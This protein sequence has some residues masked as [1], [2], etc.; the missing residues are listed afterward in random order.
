MPDKVINLAD[1][2]MR[3]YDDRHAKRVLLLNELWAGVDVDVI[4]EDLC[5]GHQYLVFRLHQ[6]KVQREAALHSVQKATQ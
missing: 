4:A 3:E 2:D 5:Y 6:E 1:L